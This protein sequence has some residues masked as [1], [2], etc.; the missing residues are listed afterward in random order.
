[1][2]SAEM[3]AF[4]DALAKVGITSMKEF[5]DVWLRAVR[6]DSAAQQ[7]IFKVT[8]D[9]RF[10]DQKVSA[11]ASERSQFL[12]RQRALREQD[13]KKTGSNRKS[14]WEKSRDSLSKSGARVVHGGLPSLGRRSK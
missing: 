11:W 5:R 14:L 9:S 13:K 4:W 1:M 3:R 7:L 12:A 10:A 8:Q 2:R 6:Q